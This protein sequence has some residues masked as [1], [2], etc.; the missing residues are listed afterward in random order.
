MSFDIAL[1]ITQDGIINGAV[2]ALLALALLLVF[3]V[4]RVIFVLQGDFISYAGLSL[5]ALQTGQVPGV[6]YVL[7]GGGLVAAGF[8]TATAIRDKAPR[9]VVLALLGYVLLPCTIAAVTWWAAPH[10]VSPLWQVLLVIALL[11]PLGAIIYR[12]AFQP[13]AKAS[14]MVLFIAAIAAHLILQGLALVSFGGE[15]VRVA[16]LS[17]MSFKLGVLQVSAQGMLIVLASVV[18]MLAL[19]LFMG[20][21]IYGQALRAT[22]FNRIGSRLVGI[23]P[24]QAGLISMLL[25]AFIGTVSGV[26]VAPI[27]TIYYDTGFLIGL[28][29]FLAAILGGMTSFPLA[30]A[31]AFFLGLMEAFA[32]FASSKFKETIVFLSIIPPLVW[33][34]LRHRHL[35]EDEE[36]DDA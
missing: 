35:S 7:V 33:L 16:P 29:G 17:D 14:V 2:Y 3:S 31:G 24:A 26:L 4:T 10:K 12:V 15:G 9:R 27:T 6:V 13:I 36:G 22:A 30:V 1:W 21:S 32:S 34:S 23:R 28:K 8:E 11:V 25:A 19:W 18:M 5:A 20:R